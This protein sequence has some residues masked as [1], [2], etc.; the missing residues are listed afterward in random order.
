VLQRVEVCL[1]ERE[2]RE[3]VREYLLPN[4]L[5]RGGSQLVVEQLDRDARVERLVELA[6][7]VGRQ[8][9]DALLLLEQAQEDADHRV[10]FDVFVRSAFH[11]HVGFVQEQDRVPCLADFEDFFELAFEHVRFGAEFADVDGVEWLLERLGGGFGGQRL[12][13]ARRAVQEED[14]APAL[15]GHKVG[16]DLAVVLDHQFDRAL[17]LGVEHQPVESVPRELD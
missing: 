5:A 13:D 10:A 15:A 17:A 16:L 2:A 7:T 3:A 11:E 9:Q 14:D 1:R 12:A 8:E 4:A 6:H